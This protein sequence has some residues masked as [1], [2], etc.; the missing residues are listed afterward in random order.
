MDE[1][2]N[3]FSPPASYFVRLHQDC[4]CSVS[5]CKLLPL[6]PLAHLTNSLLNLMNF[7]LLKIWRPRWYILLLSFQRIRIAISTNETSNIIFYVLRVCYSQRTWAISRLKENAWTS[8]PQQAQQHARC[9]WLVTV[10]DW[11]DVGFI[12][13]EEDLEVSIVACWEAVN[14]QIKSVSCLT[15]HCNTLI[16]LFCLKV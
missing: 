9:F 3:L 13:F 1:R 2:A 8:E 12:C 16:G 14:Q 6:P 4:H 15:W 11:F 5:P 10:F 7:G